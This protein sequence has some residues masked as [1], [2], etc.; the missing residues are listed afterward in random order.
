[1]YLTNDSEEI[2]SIVIKKSYAFLGALSILVLLVLGSILLSLPNKSIPLPEK[3]IATATPSKAVLAYSTCN[4]NKYDF[5]D[6]Q[7][8]NPNAEGIYALAKCCVVKGKNATT[9]APDDS[10]TRAEVAYLIARYHVN[11]RE[12]WA[13]APPNTNY[14]NDVNPADYTPLNYSLI[15]TNKYNEFLIGLNRPPFSTNCF[16]RNGARYK[17]YSSYTTSPCQLDANGDWVYGF[18]GIDRTENYNGQYSFQ[19]GNPAPFPSGQARRQYIQELYDY[20]LAKDK[21][22]GSSLGA[23]LGDVNA[24]CEI[25]ATNCSYSSP[26]TSCNTTVTWSSAGSAIAVYKD[27]SPTPLWTGNS[28]TKQDGI[29]AGPHVY[30]CKNNG[31]QLN[32]ATARAE[33]VPVAPYTIKGIVFNDKNKDTIFNSP[34]ETWSTPFS[35]NISPTT[36]TT[37]IPDY[38][39]GTYTISG[40]SNSQTY[41]ISFARPGGYTPTLPKPIQQYTSI[42]VGPGNCSIPANALHAGCGA[43][44]NINNLNFGF[45]NNSVWALFTGLDVRQDIGFDNSVPQ[46]VNA[47]CTDV[48]STAGKG[49]SSIG[50]SNPAQTGGVIFYGT[51][52]PP[53]YGAG[54]N[55]G[56]LSIFNWNVGTKFGSHPAL[57]LSYQS[58]KA[59]TTS[60][61]EFINPLFGSTSLTALTKGVW[62]A[63]G[64]LTIH[65][66][67]VSGGKKLFILAQG[68]ITIDGNIT[69]D[70]SSI[71]V[72]ASKKNIFVTN[73]V[74]LNKGSYSCVA[75]GQ[76]QGIFS[77]QGYVKV[78]G[79]NN[80]TGPVSDKMLIF[81]GNVITNADMLHSG[82]T[83]DFAERD[84]C[85]ENT[86]YPAVMIKQ[87]PD[88][89]LNFP[90]F[91]K[92]QDRIFKEVAP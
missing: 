33:Y 30:T 38:A 49:F 17:S 39:N 44:G 31:I 23:C 58:L 18:H 13:S 7:S 73:T 47:S 40:V 35:I 20:F 42:K 67:N 88:F 32:Q 68:D 3:K 77:A 59:L 52:A 70:T 26:N 29:N 48:N 9:F 4:I 41:T 5:A 86:E 25:S 91:A 36:G 19:T 37:I 80:C 64:D 82:A 24:I 53:K 66:S 16:D 1:M 76:L 46:T 51:G 27:G 10:V 65:A 69:T 43:G 75:T 83:L 79:L 28:G 15:Q 55:R 84:L 34:V 81:E 6:V 87:R 22:N 60:T 72:I 54:Y 63:P 78:K 50:Q 92:K 85:A 21:G 74:G 2:P 14:F 71:L 11:I 45:T 61:N 56:N 12:D 90:D 8:D 57:T 62:E 89:I